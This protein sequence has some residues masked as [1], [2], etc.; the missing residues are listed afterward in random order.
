MKCNIEYSELLDK[1]DLDIY[2]TLLDG[3][4]IY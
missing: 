2:E 4:M 1:F 3:M